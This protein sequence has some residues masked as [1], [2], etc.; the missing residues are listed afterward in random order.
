MAP[1]KQSLK[2]LQLE[3]LQSWLP[4]TNSQNGGLGC[5]RHTRLIEPKDSLAFLKRLRWS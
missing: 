4:S 1:P 2:T 3:V 5:V